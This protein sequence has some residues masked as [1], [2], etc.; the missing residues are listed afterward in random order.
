M[1]RFICVL[2]CLSALFLTPLRSFAVDITVPIYPQGDFNGDRKVNK[3]DADLY[4]Q[5]AS[6]W[7]VSYKQKLAADITGDGKVDG[8]DATLILQYLAGWKVALK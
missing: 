3:T 6:G 2:L 7:N 4:L 8:M 1:K 5:Y